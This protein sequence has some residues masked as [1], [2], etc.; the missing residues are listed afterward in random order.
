MVEKNELNVY[1]AFAVVFRG[2]PF[3]GCLLVVLVA[4]PPLLW[5]WNLRITLSLVVVVVLH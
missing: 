3:R 5:V 2:V 1:V 4:G